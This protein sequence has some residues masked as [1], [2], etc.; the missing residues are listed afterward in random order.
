MVVLVLVLVLLLHVPVED[1]SDVRDKQNQANVGGETGQAQGH[2]LSSELVCAPTPPVG[3]LQ[4]PDGL[5]IIRPTSTRG[6]ITAFEPIIA[7]ARRCC[8]S[9]HGAAGAS[10][11]PTASAAGAS[12]SAQSP[13]LGDI[14]KPAPKHDAN[15]RYSMGKDR[16]NTP[17]TTC[18]WVLRRLV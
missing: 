16:R 4:K 8:G 13:V 6:F 1:T 14:R 9:R 2:R 5:I 17:H 18:W 3:W 12:A 15:R 7:T 10:A 11:I